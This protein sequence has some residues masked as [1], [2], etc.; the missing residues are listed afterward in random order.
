MSS[1]NHANPSTCL[2]GTATTGTNDTTVA[3]RAYVVATYPLERRLVTLEASGYLTASDETG[4][5]LLGNGQHAVKLGTNGSAYTIP[6]EYIDTTTESTLIGKVSTRYL[7]VTY[8]VNDTK[9]NFSFSVKLFRVQAPVAPAT[10]GGANEVRYEV[11]ETVTTSECVITT[12][13][14]DSFDTV[15]SEDFGS[16]VV[17]GFH[18]IGVTFTGTIPS[19]CHV[20]FNAR[21]YTA[22]V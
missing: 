9:P 14:D 3:S 1:V 21:M 15:T 7:S 5:Y 2:V 10:S 11:A 4:T 19:N 20:Q 12:P 17:T 13:S 6:F 8:S 22:H 16:T 18:A